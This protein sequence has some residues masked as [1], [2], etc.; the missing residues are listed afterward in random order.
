MASRDSRSS[1]NV[2]IIKHQ[3]LSRSWRIVVKVDSIEKVM[4]NEKVVDK[5]IDSLIALV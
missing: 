3:Y 2:F 4:N 1:P 5:S